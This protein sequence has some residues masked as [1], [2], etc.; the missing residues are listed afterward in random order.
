[1][2]PSLPGADSIEH[3]RRVD[4]TNEGVIAIVLNNDASQSG[5]SFV[6]QDGN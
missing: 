3:C 4:L 2:I 6:I 1:M 5:K